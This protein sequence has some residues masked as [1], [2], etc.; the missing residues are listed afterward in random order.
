M[1]NAARLGV[2][3]QG[4]AVAEV[5]YQNAVTYAKERLVGA[6]AHRAEGAGQAGRSEIVHPD[7]RRM[8][9]FARTAAEG[10]RALATVHRQ[11]R[12]GSSDGPSEPSGQARRR[13]PIC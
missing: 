6:R 2:G 5:A 3:V 8:L 11:S 4:V 13:S 9:L 1:M 10:G 7:V 12:R